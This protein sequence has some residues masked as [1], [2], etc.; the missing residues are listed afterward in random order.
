MRAASVSLSSTM[1][2]K[3]ASTSNIRPRTVCS[4]LSDLSQPYGTKRKVHG[5]AATVGTTAGPVGGRRSAAPSDSI[6]AGIAQ[7]AANWDAGGRD[8]SF[9]PPVVCHPGVYQM[10]EV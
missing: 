5:D 9:L 8:L 7:S 3:L 10:G 4:P 2:M 6:R 1:S